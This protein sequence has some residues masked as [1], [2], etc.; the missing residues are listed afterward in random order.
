MGDCLIIT[1]AKN[2]IELKLP[3]TLCFDASYCQGEYNKDKSKYDPPG[4]V[5][6]L[7]AKMVQR[8]RIIS[9]E[10]NISIMEQ[11]Q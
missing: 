5:I 2:E 1:A 6:L 3:H 10:S 9:T 7:V 4:V 11:L 8:T